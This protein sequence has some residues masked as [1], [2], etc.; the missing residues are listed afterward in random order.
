MN[1]ERIDPE[2][3]AALIDGRLDAT[4][5][6]RVLAELAAHPEEYEVFADAVRGSA[7]LATTAPVARLLRGRRWVVA[8]PALAAAGIAA[9]VLWPRW[10]GRPASTPV[11]L[12]SRLH[13]VSTT[14]PGSLQ[15]R[16]GPGWDQ[17]GWAM[18]RGDAGDL[19]ESAREFRIGV[20]A[21]D[22]EL[23]FGARDSIALAEAGEELLGLLGSSQGGDGLADRFRRLLESGVDQAGRARAEAAEALRQHL[24]DS[25]WFGLGAWTEAARLALAAGDDP[26]LAGIRSALR[27]LI[28]SLER[29]AV[30]TSELTQLLRRLDTS[31]GSVQTPEERSRAGR[32]IHDVVVVA[33]R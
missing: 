30:D 29:L 11:E 18:T 20:R 31:L 7:G 14:G 28:R 5:R 17:P 13:L 8:I 19:V 6:A 26:G 24:D 9:V 32:L 1:S 15:A 33:G 23:A 2:T 22:V 27:D 16:L 4:E 10:T 12:A 21:I 3:L 25:P